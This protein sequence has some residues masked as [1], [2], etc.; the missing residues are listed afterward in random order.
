MIRTVAALWPLLFQFREFFSR[1]CSIRSVS[2]LLPAFCIPLPFH[3]F[4]SRVCSMRSVSCLLPAFCI[5][6]TVSVLLFVPCALLRFRVRW[7]APWTA[8]LPLSAME[9]VIHAVAR[10]CSASVG[11]HG[12]RDPRCGRCSVPLL[13]LSLYVFR[14]YVLLNT[15][16][17]FF[18]S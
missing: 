14:F 7:S 18:F 4:F 9:A 1:V 5:P 17:V 13:P 8:P 12:G 2:C 10:L 15:Q 16:S 11:G 3:E 6:P